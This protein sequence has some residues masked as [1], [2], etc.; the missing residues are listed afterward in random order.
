MRFTQNPYSLL[1]LALASTGGAFAVV[2]YLILD[3]VPLTALGISMAILGAICL[4]L[5]RT[6]PKIPPEVSIILLETGLENTAAIVEELGLRSKAIYLPPS[7]SGGHPR[8][9]IPLHSNPGPYQIQIGKV[10]PGRLIAKY[11]PA[12]EDIGILVTTPGS[13]VAGIPGA[14]PGPCVDGL[15][16][17]LTSALVGMLDVA[18]R[19]TVN[20]T[21]ESVFIEVA[22]PRLEQ[23]NLWFYEL[24]GSPLASVVASLAAE[25]L[26]KP[27]I[28]ES[29]THGKGKLMIELRVLD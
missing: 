9:L 23:R 14:E 5:A 7:F 2:S 18:D 27:I 8:A 13:S 24:L 20:M 22:N 25:A 19:A 17:S 15:E 1:G 26:D 16:A 21:G 11:G 28:V 12:P 3:S 6:R 4:T 10:L 29:E